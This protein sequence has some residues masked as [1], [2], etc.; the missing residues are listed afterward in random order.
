MNESR[1]LTIDEEHELRGMWEQLDPDTRISWRD[2]WLTAQRDVTKAETLKE[3]GEA[4]E[5]KKVYQSA[6]LVTFNMDWE[7]FKKKALKRGEINKEH[8]D[9]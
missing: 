3:V 4:L 6:L 9:G 7:R 8:Q 2:F 1:I 5:S